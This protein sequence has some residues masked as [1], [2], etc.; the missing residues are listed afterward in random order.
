MGWNIKRKMQCIFDRGKFDIV[1]IH[2][3]TVPTLPIIAHLT[4]DIPT[5]GTIHTYFESSILYS[6][7]HQLAQDVMEN[8]DGRIAVSELC[9]RSM[10]KYIKAKFEIIPNGVDVDYFSKSTGRLHKYDDGKINILFVGRLDPRNGLECLIKAFRLVYKKNKNIRLIVVGDGPL[11]SYYNILMKQNEDIHFEGYV[12]DLRPDYY[13]LSDIFCFPVQKASFGITILEAMAAGKPI[14]CSELEAFHDILGKEEA[15][16][17]IDPYDEYDLAAKLT[18]LIED[19]QLRLNLGESAR[20]KVERFSWINVTR[21]V[22]DY[23]STILNRAPQ[24]LA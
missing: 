1:H 8:L 19:K 24:T 21:E 9:V 15:C 16:R 20:Q 11:R 10:Q 6:I 17:Y 5:V 2:A 23:Y 7:Y 14:V 12:N 22:L 3:P 4:S 13:A 18:E